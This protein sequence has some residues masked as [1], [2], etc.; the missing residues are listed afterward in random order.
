MM[1]VGIFSFFDNEGIVDEYVDKLLLSM[2]EVLTKL[3][4][5]VNGKLTENSKKLLEKYTDVIILRENS[6]YDAGA[7]KNVVLDYFSEDDWNTYD[8]IVLFNST[9]Y[10]P[11]FSMEDI[12]ETFS[13]NQNIDFWGLSKWIGGES[14]LLHEKN[15]PAHIQTYFIV[16]KKRIL[17]SDYWFDFWKKMNY[18][19]DYADA[20]RNFEVRFTTYFSERGFHYRTWLEEQGGEELMKTGK[21]VYNEYPYKMISNYKFPILKYKAV[22]FSNLSQIINSAAFIEKN[23]NYDVNMIWRHLERL[24][25]FKRMT[26]F[27]IVELEK[28]YF[29]HEKIYIFGYGKY[30]K[31]MEAYFDYRKWNIEGFIVSDNQM[32][33][34]LLLLENVKLA[35]KDGVIIALGKKNFEQMKEI[36]KKR[37]NEEQLLFPVYI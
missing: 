12:F 26:P 4:I 15:L 14:L 13:M 33:K 36:L 21:V 32:D 25:Q 20:I 17:Q 34:E 24:Q 31:E 35:A 28:F 30:G 22:T 6:G 3:Y 27:L 18:P 1:R 23:C 19:D 2:Q 5:V 7:Y 9:F 29:N 10:G 16:I 37:F 8:E 11:F